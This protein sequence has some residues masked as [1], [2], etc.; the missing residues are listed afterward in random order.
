MQKP[1]PDGPRFSLMISRLFS[2]FF[3]VVTHPCMP[4]QD[5]LTNRPKSSVLSG[6]RRRHLHRGGPIMMEGKG[7]MSF[8]RFFRLFGLLICVCLENNKRSSLNKQLKMAAA[9]HAAVH[10]WQRRSAR[11]CQ[12]GL[13][14]AALWPLIYNRQLSVISG[15]DTFCLN[16]CN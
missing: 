2:S 14:R 5:K 11:C 7:E 9:R 16:A 4:C 15:C 1:S 3:S 13:W 12:L 8:E 10:M 6:N